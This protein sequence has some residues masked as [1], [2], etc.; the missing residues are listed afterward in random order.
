MKFEILPNKN[1]KL[2]LQRGDR[3]D[4]RELVKSNPD[5]RGFLAEL[6]EHT[7]WEP[8]GSLFLLKPEDVG[9]LTEAPILTDDMS[10]EDDG[11]VT[12]HGNVWWYPSYMLHHFGEELL[13]DGYVI[14]PYAP[15][16]ENQASAPSAGT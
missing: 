5:D 13:K 1:L 12:V 3:K 8:N 6:L 16:V 15:P 14:F 9:G 11:S 2:E 10:I 7:G 4:I